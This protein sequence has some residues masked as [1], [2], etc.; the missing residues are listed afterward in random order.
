MQDFLLLLAVAAILI[1]GYYIVEKLDLFLEC[2]RKPEGLLPAADR[3]SLKIGFS[4]P[5]AIDYLSDILEQYSKMK[6]EVS[7]SLFSGTE[8]E[9]NQEFS[10]RRLDV[11][12]LSGS[13]VVPKKMGDNIREVLLSCAP[14]IRQYGGLAV[15]PITKE[16]ISCYVIW[17]DL[18]GKPAIRY[19]V[20][21]LMHAEGMECKSGRDR[22][23]MI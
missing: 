5:L 11:I 22:Q 19:F 2:S 17:S 1:F 9:L 20:E 14:V 23:K 12:F 6:P 16:R 3:S 13:T 4:N 21:C 8:A 18:K 10:A 15:E 7:V